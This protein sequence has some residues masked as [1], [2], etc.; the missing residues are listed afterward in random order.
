MAGRLHP[1]SARAAPPGPAPAMLCWRSMPEL[2]EVQAL[3]EALEARARGRRVAALTIASVA[4]LKTHDPAPL[5]AS[6]RTLGG[7]R[8][9]GKFL[10][11][12]L[13]A[14]EEAAR[15]ASLFLVLHLARAGWLRWRETTTVA[16]LAQ[17]GP[18]A[19]RLR[20]EDG[21]A[22]DATEQGTEKR[23]AVFLVRAPGDVPGVAALGVDA[24]DPDLD[25]IRLGSL[26]RARP[27]SLKAALSDQS[28]IA[29]LGNAYSDEVLHA[30]RLS[31]FARADR[32][33]PAELD[34]LALALRDT[35]HAA[36]QRARRLDTGDLKEGKRAAMRVHGRSGQP[37]PECG[38]TVRAVAY[39]TRSFQY[40]PTC[41]T[42][43]RVYADRRLSRLLR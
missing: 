30:A 4:A 8:R 28:V 40:C 36:L 41:Q 34:R 3:T 43:G 16:R 6:G 38:D 42:G 23:L 2:P 32:L 26:L 21:A 27:G 22:L 18:L 9:H 39:A 1:S 17:R 13:V 37:C 19:A 35:L 11:I 7:V 31:P 20:F 33:A 12:E 24:L 14:G 15:P 29:G 5:A 10:A 25:G